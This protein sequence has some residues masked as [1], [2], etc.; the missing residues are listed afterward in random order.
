[1][2]LILDQI[3]A[4]FNTLDWAYI[5]TL[6]LLVYAIS[7]FKYS[8]IWFEKL[9]ISQR[10]R[11]LII[12]VLYGIIIY[13]IRNSSLEH[14]ETLFQSFVFALVFHKLIIDKLIQFIFQAKN[15]NKEA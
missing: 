4:Y 13:Y 14:I 8:Q 12:G 11:V 15:Q 2:T 7:N 9:N 10:Y 6:I 1:M 3:T 5:L